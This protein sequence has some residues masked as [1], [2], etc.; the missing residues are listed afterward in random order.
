MAAQG[1]TLDK[2]VINIESDAGKSTSNIDKLATSLYNLK[3]AIS[4]GFGNINKLANGL[5]NLSESTANLS[6]IGAKLEPL[7]KLGAALSPLTNIKANGF[8]KL[9]NNLGQIPT[10]MNQI[11]PDALQNVAR[12]SGQLADSLSPLASKMS[13]ISHGYSALSGLADKYGVSVTKVH[14]KSQKTINVLDRLKNGLSKLSTPFK[15]ISAASE[16][17]GKSAIKQFTKVNSKL[18]QIGLSLLGTR[19]IFTATRKAVSEYMNMDI[20]LSDKLS[21]VWRGLG[22]LMAP[23]IE[24]VIY[25][26]K[27]FAR[28]IYSVIKALTGIDLIAIANEKAMA[29]WGKSTKDLLGSLQKFD[30]L[31]VVDFGKSGSGDDNKLIDLPEIDLTPIQKI[32]DWVKKL[33]EEIQAALDTGQWYNVGAVFAEGINQAFEAI[34]IDA[35]Y[36]KLSSVATKF[37]DFLN[38]VIENTN[39]ELIG[40]K[41]SG[42]F[43]TLYQT[44]NDLIST[45]NFD[46]IGQ[47]FSD[48]IAGFD[49]SGLV[50]TISDLVISITTGLA[51]AFI[52]IDWEIVSTKLSDAT[53]VFLDKMNTAL[54]N[55]QWDKI[56]ESIR[57]AIENIDWLGIINGIIDIV[58]NAIS[59]AGSLL[60]GLFGT[61]IFSEIADTVNGLIDDITLI[62][63]TIGNTLGEGSTASNA[64]KAI[65]NIVSNLVGF[66]KIIGDTLT[67]WMLSEDFQDVI[68]S[69]EEIIG[70]IFDT[71]DSLVSTVVEWWQ[72]D[73]G[74][75]LR[76][77]L[78]ELTKII[79]VC[80]EPIIE[81]IK[82]LGG[83]I[84]WV[85]DTILKPIWT[86][87]FGVLDIFI[88]I[89]SG[90]IQFVVKVFQ[91]DIK[92]AFESIATTVQNVG[93]KIKN[94]WKKLVNSI[95]GL[96][97]SFINKIIGGINGLIDKLNK[98]SIKMP[99]WLPGDLGGKKFGFN[100]SHLA[101]I[102]IPK[103]ATGTNEI[104]YE[105]LYHLHPGEAVVP[106]KYNPA[107]G[108]TDN[109]EETNQ[110][111][112]R[113]I[114]IMENFKINNTINIGNKK[115]YEEQQNFNTYQNNK[116]G[117]L[118]I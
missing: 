81:V 86:Y 66:V 37:G 27:Q 115:I 32:V 16:S 39:W 82:E 112:D 65:E 99:D 107:L 13:E 88:S 23:A 24:E 56:G 77:I 108:G 55:I 57:I 9:I 22:A 89:L 87:V 10:V 74:D 40:E 52:N 12:V 26:F 61:N 63:T 33:K 110:R 98:I 30:D 69:V 84:K 34:N 97:E 47:A 53:L 93:E 106:K 109:S 67:D 102:S 73:G 62:G 94:V 25:L 80:L 54:T 36:E 28:V 14:E 64:F 21:N 70:V 35:I 18:K 105:G 75:I 51:D 92:G 44:I 76:S 103:L 6:D 60:D 15:K 72:S 95:T 116:Y 79:K 19:T 42:L 8:N 31:N 90:I 59:G 49:L 114:S 29:G 48:F 46:S 4:G 91:G 1:V 58:K 41:I 68:A 43:V 7:S 45:I 104:P 100:I 118:N 83:I 17:F 5:K 113:L 117:T 71:V 101:E 50:G 38:G 2:V 20:E 3:S 78:S 85:V 11:T 111:L 96:V